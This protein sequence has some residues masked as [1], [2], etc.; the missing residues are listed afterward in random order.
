MMQKSVLTI[1]TA[2]LAISAFGL[3]F[4]PSNMLGVVGISSS[5]QADFL[6]RTTGVGVAALIPGAWVAR[7]LTASSPI[8]R[9]VLLGLASYMLLSVAVDFQA[10]TQ[11]IVNTASIPSMAFRILLGSG[12]LMLAAKTWERTK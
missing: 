9:A 7:T 8:L 12:L 5:A 10:F 3:L 2:V 1:T 4:F 11:S 6:L